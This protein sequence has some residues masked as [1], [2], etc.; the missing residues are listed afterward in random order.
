M[1][2]DEQ[3]IKTNV[4][5]EQLDE[6]TKVG[7]DILDA[8]WVK[9]HM[10]VTDT[11]RSVFVEAG[12]GAGKTTLIIQRV[13]NQ[14][15]N[16][17]VTADQLVI[18]TFTKK[19]A[20]ELATRVRLELA[21]QKKKLTKKVDSGSAS[22]QDIKE[23]RRVEE[24][25]DNIGRMTVSTIHSF[26]YKI[27]KENAFDAELRMDI[28][29][30]E[31]DDE[32]AAKTSIFE[33]WFATLSSLARAELEQVLGW[34]YKSYLLSTFLEICDS[35]EDVEIKY[36]PVAAAQDYNLWSV[37]NDAE[38]TK[39][40]NALEDE[41]VKKIGQKMNTSYADFSAITTLRCVSS[42]ATAYVRKIHNEYS[43]S[44]GLDCLNAV[45]GKNIFMF[46][47]GAGVSFEES[48]DLNK[49]IS[50]SQPMKELEKI[51]KDKD[52]IIHA[53]TVKYALEARDYYKKHW[54]KRYIT[55]DQLL[56]YAHKMVHQNSEVC[57]TL[58]NRYRSFY[59]DEFQDV[60]HIQEE[61][62]WKL[63]EDPNRPGCLKPGAVFFV[64]DPKQSIYRFRGA[65]PEI[66][67][68]IKNRMIGTKEDY[69]FDLQYNF[70]SSK[71]IID[72][73]NAAFSTRLNIYQSMMFPPV[74][75]SSTSKDAKLIEGVYLFNANALDDKISGRGI[76]KVNAEA[77]YI[78][79]MIEVM[80][81][82][83]FQ[84]PEPTADNPAL[85]RDIVYGDFLILV[86]YIR[87]ADC[88]AN[89]LM[90][91]GIPV[92]L[93]ADT[94]MDECYE[95][96]LF[97]LMFDY[98]SNPYE[99]YARVGAQQH[100][101]D[102][103]DF[104]AIRQE[105]SGMNG[106][107]IT[108]YLLKHTEYFV[109][110]GAVKTANDMLQIQ[111]KLQQMIESVMTVSDGN[112]KQMAKQYAEYLQKVSERQLPLKEENC[113]RIMNVHKSKGL[114]GRIVI[115]ANRNNL[116]LDRDGTVQRK[117]KIPKGQYR[118]EKYP[119]V[120]MP[121]IKRAE[122][123]NTSPYSMPSY[124]GYAKDEKLRDECYK[125]DKEEQERLDYVTVTRAQD[126]FIFMPPKYNN[127]R[128]MDFKY[129]EINTQ[130]GLTDAKS[131][132][133]LMKENMITPVT[134]PTLPVQKA[135]QAPSDVDIED[136]LSDVSVSISPSALEYEEKKK[137]LDEETVDEEVVVVESGAEEKQES[138]E[139]ATA[140][141]SGK[142]TPFA[143]EPIARPCG[144]IFGTMMH[145][146][147]E[148]LVLKSSKGFRKD[149]IKAYIDTAIQ[150]A[151]TENYE[152]CLHRYQDECEEVVEG[153]T[154]YLKTIAEKFLEDESMQRRMKNAKVYPELEFKFYTSVEK[155]PE[156]FQALQPYLDQKHIDV[157][158]KDVFVAGTAD[159]VLVNE[160]DGTIHIIDYKSDSR[161]RLTQDE[162]L[163]HLEKYNGQL[164]LYKYAIA[165]LFDID[166]I[167]RVTTELYHLYKDE[168]TI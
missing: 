59:V 129:D 69:V 2:I 152:D 101:E 166:D 89:C 163:E 117:L 103:L 78:A 164:L 114:E 40:M 146:V 45:A 167:S 137:R 148:L 153:F 76:E 62:V 94:Y 157:A 151:V 29:M 8:E 7:V 105:T 4:T 107:E 51:K 123:K 32:I 37:I 100:W 43:P 68:E 155:D 81:N 48:Q 22:E 83:H 142:G 106:Y 120:R 88:I 44:F 24:A 159:L 85:T 6:M 144:N 116:M 102:I 82:D 112:A 84:L 10:I 11:K 71:K 57:K 124:V 64:G 31:G 18:I 9:R 79:R 135:F 162:F 131:I 63:G 92:Q 98:L 126:A 41:M 27:L 14:I 1:I 26:C 154:T 65:D 75:V 70:R 93:S 113:V 119:F 54:D 104:E 134:K 145:R 87:N 55:N 122:Y 143:T 34:N 86:P 52:T 35:P 109:P 110:M 60:D 97:Q 149:D 133:Q 136:L 99:S 138:E 168:I 108:E 28:Q 16:G 30:L 77:K 61:F 36:D 46:C 38:V 21:E 147:F 67:T 56:Q 47:K 156:M 5:K 58:Q 139:S 161:G 72:W 96:K 20:E 80:V 128:M 121:E 140:Q 165:K 49:E 74:K 127:V 118:Y 23:K 12:A 95:L 91:K 39:Q 33:D 53:K 66:Y 42:A 25:L 3:Y 13:L 125:K 19:A 90:E 17:D 160:A 15:K 73:V 141:S 132:C 111:T 150:L 130:I 158:G 50:G 115:L